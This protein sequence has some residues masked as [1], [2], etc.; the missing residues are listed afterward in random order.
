MDDK[1]ET[2][3]EQFM[4]INSIPE[5]DGAYMF[6]MQIK[7]LIQSIG[8]TWIDMR[9]LNSR[10]EKFW[11]DKLK[12]V[13]IIRESHIPPAP[14]ML[15][16][17]EAQ[18]SLLIELSN[19]VITTGR[20][21]MYLTCKN[22]HISINTQDSAELEKCKDRFIQ[23]VSSLLPEGIYFERKRG[24]AMGILTLLLFTDAFWKVRK[25]SLKNGLSCL[26][27]EEA[28]KKELNTCIKLFVKKCPSIHPGIVMN[29]TSSWLSYTIHNGKNSIIIEEGVV[30]PRDAITVEYA[31]SS[32]PNSRVTFRNKKGEI[33][34]QIEMRKISGLCQLQYSNPKQKDNSLTGLFKTFNFY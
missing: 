24:S 31:L 10:H 29:L 20:G 34:Y 3:V 1:Q 22:I 17:M 11:S 7:T 4:I 23:N 8:I 6:L 30:Y 9:R 19:A 2:S 12:F 26:D 14:Y 18:K 33:V 15:L 21:M 27:I 25:S 13:I 16:P 5:N 32:Y 28:T